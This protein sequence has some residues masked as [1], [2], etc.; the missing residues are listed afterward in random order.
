MLCL[1]THF[2]LVVYIMFHNN[3]N[4]M[5]NHTLHFDAVTL[6]IIH[7][8]SGVFYSKLGRRQRNSFILKIQT[9]RQ[10]IYPMA[11]SWTKT[12]KWLARIVYFQ[13]ISQLNNVWYTVF[14][15][16]AANSVRYIALYN[17]E[18]RSTYELSI[19]KGEL[20]I[21]SQ[22]WEVLLK[23]FCKLFCF[24]HDVFHFC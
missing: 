9:S 18:A 10:Q 20:F 24:F 19:T 11:K 23:V 21:I 13:L 7:Y 3:L 14:C 5:K 6:S 12:C 17:Y 22:R 1:V 8:T 15:A 2:T 4:M 16:F